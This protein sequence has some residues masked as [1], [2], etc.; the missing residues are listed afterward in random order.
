[1]VPS[2]SATTKL[3]LTP[4]SIIFFI[5]AVVIELAQSAVCVD[6]AMHIRSF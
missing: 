2:V 5:V 3:A 6:V 1:M 4:E